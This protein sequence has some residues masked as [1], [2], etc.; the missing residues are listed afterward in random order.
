MFFISGNRSNYKFRNQKNAHHD[1]SKSNY[2]YMSASKVKS[3][4]NDASQNGVS[5][6]SRSRGYIKHFLANP[7]SV[8]SDPHWIK[9]R[10]AF[11]ARHKAS[12]DVNPTPR[13]RLALIMWAYCPD[14]C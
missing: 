3:Y 4:L 13:R 1:N 10:N 9:Q 2:P 12:Y 7:E 8:K 11:I 14:N 6:V 5:E